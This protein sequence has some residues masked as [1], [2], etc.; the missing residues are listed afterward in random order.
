MDNR[1]WCTN[2]NISKLIKNNK[3]DSFLENNKDWKKG[4]V[5]NDKTRNSISKIRTN[6]C[7][8]IRDDG[9]KTVINKNEVDSFLENNKDWKKGKKLKQDLKK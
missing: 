2:G 7:W 3:V 9:K 6:K 1:T 8:I 4:K 5:V